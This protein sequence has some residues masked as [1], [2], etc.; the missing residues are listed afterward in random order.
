MRA[1]AKQR[2]Q[3]LDLPESKTVILVPVSK[4]LTPFPVWLWE[5]LAFFLSNRGYVVVTNV[6]ASQM[7]LCVPLTMPLA[8]PP[9]ELIPI[10]ELAG[11]VISARCGVCDVLSTANTD[12][13][14]IYQRPTVEWKPMKDVTMEWDLGPCGL[15]DRATYIRLGVYETPGDFIQRILEGL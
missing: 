14:I 6:P 9:E 3:K 15:E 12:L 13:R 7:E 2:M 5:E 1:N 11:V 8:C 4:S 10:A